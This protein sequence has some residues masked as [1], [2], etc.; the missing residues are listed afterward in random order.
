MCSE[1]LAQAKSLRPPGCIPVNGCTATLRML[2]WRGWKVGGS[3]W[4]FLYSHISSSG[5]NSLST[6]ERFYLKTERRPSW[7]AVRHPSTHMWKNKPC[8][9]QLR[10]HLNIAVLTVQATCHLGCWCAEFELIHVIFHVGNSRISLITF[11]RAITSGTQ[12]FL[13]SHFT[14]K[15]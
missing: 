11:S 7:S 5:G 14:L 8:H 6:L 3:L 10:T 2:R 4:A 9:K 1:P 15:V 13:P 12:H